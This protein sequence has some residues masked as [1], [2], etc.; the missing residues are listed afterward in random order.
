MALASLASRW[1]QWKEGHT[2]RLDRTA[3]SEGLHSSNTGSLPGWPDPTV[4]GT[5]TLVWSRLVP[6]ASGTDS[7]WV[8]IGGG[9]PAVLLWER[10]PSVSSCF[11]LP[12]RT[13]PFLRQSV[14]H[15]VT[16]SSLGHHIQPLW[17]PHSLPHAVGMPL[18]G[19]LF[20]R[21]P[22]SNRSGMPS[23]PTTP[24]PGRGKEELS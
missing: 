4:L 10:P 5:S 8:D 3:P 11:H 14:D 21:S 13:C 6:K 22:L 18:S 19:H 20:K 17:P 16:H 15:Q 12:W 9:P 24:T 23:P 7:R 2:G 1:V